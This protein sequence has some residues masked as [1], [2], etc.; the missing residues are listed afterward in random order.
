MRAAIF[1]AFKSSRL[2]NGS[3]VI[4]TDKQTLKQTLLKTLP[5]SLREDAGH[6]PGDEDEERCAPN[7]IRCCYQL[8]YGINWY[9]EASPG[10]SA[11][12]RHLHCNRV[13]V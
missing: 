13:C 6:I 10:F 1:S 8:S 12:L 4:V 9:Y 3:G 2:R 11:S 7:F 5:P